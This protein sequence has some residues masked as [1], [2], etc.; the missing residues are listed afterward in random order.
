[1]LAFYTLPY[2]CDF[3]RKFGCVIFRLDH[4][5]KN[6]WYDSVER[7]DCQRGQELNQKHNDGVVIG[8]IIGIRQKLEWKSRINERHVLLATIYCTMILYLTYWNLAV[9]WYSYSSL[10]KSVFILNR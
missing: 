10:A 7:R 3:Y 8:L 5:S 2:K 9:Y 1:M 4:N 6:Q